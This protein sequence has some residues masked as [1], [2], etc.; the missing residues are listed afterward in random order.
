MKRKE[1]NGLGKKEESSLQASRIT[2]R[3]SVKRF[4]YKKPSR[5]KAGDAD[6]EPDEA[7]L[8]EIRRI[9]KR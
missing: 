3:A 8:E 5:W 6:P 4:P 9:G 1:K 7:E 2:P